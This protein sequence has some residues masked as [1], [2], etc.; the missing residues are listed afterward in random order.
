MNKE[1][2]NKLFFSPSLIAFAGAIV[3]ILI[4]YPVNLVTTRAVGALA[5]LVITVPVEEIAKVIGIIFLLLRYP[6]NLG[7]KT[8]G[9]KLGAIAGLTFGLFETAISRSGVF[10]LLFSTPLHVM[11]S[12]IVGI[13]LAFSAVQT[14]DKNKTLSSILTNWQTGSFFLIAMGIHF[15]YNFLAFTLREAGLI[16]G[17]AAVIFV[18]IRLYKSIPQEANAMS[19]VTPFQLLFRTTPPKPSGHKQKPK[20]INYCSGCGAKIKEGQSFCPQCGKKA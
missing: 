8:Q 6:E 7:G 3:S 14:Q 13:G 9:L 4:V 12:G 15:I 18:F 16:I 1:S 5:G 20:T 11:C 10:G 19:G 17:F 2:K